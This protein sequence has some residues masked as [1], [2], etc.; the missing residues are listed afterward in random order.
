[1]SYE[2]DK[3]KLVDPE[4]ERCLI[5][6]ECIVLELLTILPDINIAYSEAVTKYSDPKKLLRAQKKFQNV[7][8]QCKNNVILDQGSQFESFK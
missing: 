3:P 8:T 6:F 5:I 7:I 4:E 2:G 1:M